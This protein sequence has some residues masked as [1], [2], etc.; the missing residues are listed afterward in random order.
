[1]ETV[2]VIY[3]EGPDGGNKVVVDVMH[4]MERRGSRADV[5]GDD[6]LRAPALLKFQI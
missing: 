1:M 2:N 5:D 3:S 4:Y 6:Q